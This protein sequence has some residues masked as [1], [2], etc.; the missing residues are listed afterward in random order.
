MT[1]EMWEERIKEWY[2]D[3]RP[4][5]LVFTLFRVP[6]YSGFHFVPDFILFSVPFYLVSILFWVSFYPG[7]HFIPDSKLFWVP[8]L[9]RFHF[10]LGFIFSRFHFIL[11]SENQVE[12]NH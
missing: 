2:A 12:W 4:F 8:F 9:S 6:F 7:F 11:G 10:I 3:H 1:A 5:Y